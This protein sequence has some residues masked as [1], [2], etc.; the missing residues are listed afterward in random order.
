MRFALAVL[1]CLVILTAC[2]LEKVPATGPDGSWWVGGSDGGVFVKITDDDNPSDKFY[3]GTI[4]YE[5]DQSVWYRGVFKLVG[6]I[7]FSPEKR[8]QYLAWDGERLHL[9]GSSYL[10]ATEDFPGS[11]HE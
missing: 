11:E 1:C 7:E 10:E 9:T 6:D 8:D 2:S 3:T 5:Y 4:Y